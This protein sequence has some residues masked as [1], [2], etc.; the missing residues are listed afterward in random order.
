V[1]EIGYRTTDDGDIEILYKPD[2]DTRNNEQRE[3]KEYAARLA[4]DERV[5]RK[6]KRRGR[7][8]KLSHQEIRELRDST[9]SD[10]AFIASLVKAGY[11]Q[12]TARQ[13]CYVFK[14]E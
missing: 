9:G 7:K 2:Q 1:K 8:S 13:Y 6:K 14:K 4:H 10:E 11:T 12:L 5:E 3:L